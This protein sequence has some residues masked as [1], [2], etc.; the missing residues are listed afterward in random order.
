MAM[1]YQLVVIVHV[2][3][4]MV[5]FGAGLGLPRRL[6][7]G[8]ARGR[9]EA[10]AAAE[11]A[12][13]GS[14]TA[15]LAALATIATGIALVLIGGGFALVSPRIHLGLAL[16]ALALLL[17]LVTRSILRKAERS[18]A[19]EDDRASALPRV[20]R[21]AMTQGMTHLLIVIVLGLMVWRLA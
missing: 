16:T 3:L 13:R 11:D 8:I 19:S 15:I 20:R 10:T 5:W 12:M 7:A 4:T 17:E 21:A 9:S 6:R 1:A 18:I 2:A 14:R